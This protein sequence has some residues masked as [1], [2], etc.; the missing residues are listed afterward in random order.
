MNGELLSLKT[1]E[2][3]ARVDK[4]IRKISLIRMDSDTSIET[5]KALDEV[6]KILLGREK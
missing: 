5:H 4:A 3:L 6:L 2:K 1:A